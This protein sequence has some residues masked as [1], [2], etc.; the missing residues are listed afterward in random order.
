ML[1]NNRH[2]SVDS[3]TYRYGFNG[4][5]GDDEVKGEGNI[6]TT[7]FRKFDPRLGRTFSLD[8]V[9]RSEISMYSMM[10]N[11]PIIMID[12]RG[13][14][15][16]FSV[17]G[18]YLGSDNKKS[19]FIR[20]ICE[21]NEATFY[22]SIVMGEN[23]LESISS[24]IGDFNFNSYENEYLLTNITNYYADKIGMQGVAG[25]SERTDNEG[26]LTA[27][28][29]TVGKSVIYMGID[30][31]GN[32]SSSMID[33][34][35]IQSV[36]VHENGHVNDKEES[37]DLDHT[38]RYLEQIEHPTFDNITDEYKYGL[39]IKT[40][41]YMNKYLGR[42]YTGRQL[43]KVKERMEEFNS[44]S[45]FTGFKLITDAKNNVSVE[46]VPTI[47]FEIEPVELEMKN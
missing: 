47:R 13:D 40:A 21:G 44:Q 7:Y 34:Y 4:M 33:A 18:Q 14:D 5:E 42:S 15:D 39:F 1:L 16:Y 8:P 37:T 10:S 30:G 20:V 25:V 29:V 12:P 6:Y 28:A 38:K 27:N 32:M 17:T 31:N 2:G 19:N 46:E 22:S 9:M 24:S 26:N 35:N 45:V 36:I 23:H 11:N 3:D 43:E 41:Y